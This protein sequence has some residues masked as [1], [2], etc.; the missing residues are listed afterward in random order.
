QIAAAAQA[1]ADIVELHTGRFCHQPAGG[2]AFNAEFE[3]L[4]TAARQ[5]AALGLEVHAGHG[6]DYDTADWL[7]RLP[8]VA[9]LNIGHFLVGEASS[10]GLG[11]AIRRMREA[12]DRGRGRA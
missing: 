5:A 6:L 8:E 11:P 3:R 10:A 4:A 9:E 2:E 7:A 12:I 1:G